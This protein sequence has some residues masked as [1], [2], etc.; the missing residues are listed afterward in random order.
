MGDLRYRVVK[1][2]ITRDIRDLKTGDESTIEDL[3]EGG[4]G[5]DITPEQVKTLYEGNPDTNAYTDG[6][7]AKLDGVTAGATA[8]QTNAYL[9]ARGNHTGSQAVSTVTGLQ[10]ALD[11][12]LPTTDA[13]LTAGAAGVATV[14]A[15]GTTATT[16][17]AGNHTHPAASGTAS[18]LMTSAQF[19]KLNGVAA[20]ANNYVLPSPTTTAMGGLLSVATPTI[21]VADPLDVVQVQANFDAIIDA[22]KAA[23]VFV[24]P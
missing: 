20:N 21:T 24:D 17:A 19:T 18:G 4:S 7:K 23:G 13:R 6:D 14:R 8:N 9:L 16:A 5:G 1:R 15:I 11:A 10:A 12:K 3:I 2:Q 22:L